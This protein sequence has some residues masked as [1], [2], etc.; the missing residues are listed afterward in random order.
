MALFRF[1]DPSTG[2]LRLDLR[3]RAGWYLAEGLDLGRRSL[4][5]KWLSQEGVDGAELAS[6]WREPVQMMVPLILTP[7]SSGAAVETLMNN[8]NTELRRATNG[9]EYLPDGL[10][11]SWGAS[12]TWLIN[13]YQ[14]DE[15]SLQDGL[16]GSEWFRRQGKL[17]L[18]LTIF[19]DPAFARRSAT[20]I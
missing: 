16:G 15:V 12:T 7:Q 2:T 11:G 20:I 6:T 10:S 13:T 8:L 4:T 19:R 3:D 1:V 5:Y 9:I 18:P 17:I 14:A